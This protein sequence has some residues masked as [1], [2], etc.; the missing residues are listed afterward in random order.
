MA[1]SARF[2]FE[3]AD[4]STTLV[5]S[6]GIPKTATCFGTAAIRTAQKSQGSSSLRLPGGLANYA[7]IQA[8]GSELLMTGDYSLSIWAYRDVF[9]ADECIFETGANALDLQASISFSNCNILFGTRFGVTGG[10]QIAS[11]SNV[12]AGEWHNYGFMRKGRTT[13]AFVDGNRIGSFT[14][15]TGLY[16]IDLSTIIIG[17]RRENTR[18][19]TG[20][21][22]DLF[23]DKGEALWLYGYDPFTLAPYTFDPKIVANQSPLLTAQLYPYPV[24][25]KA[26]LPLGVVRREYYGGT[27]RIYGTVKVK[28]T[29][30]NVPVSRK[31]RLYD[32]AQGLP[33][34]ETWSHPETG[35]YEFAGYNPNIRYMVLSYDFTQ[36]YRAVVADMLIAEV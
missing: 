2:F 11:A 16:N 3:G 14:D 13:F 10:A 29:P 25:Y 9:L 33:I 36:S 23:I 34:A 17:K 19:M 26:T 4:G 28:G 21:V 31:V 18:P 6:S 27:A 24:Q 32:Q 15:S 30:T 7:Q 5:D 20:Y 12:P 8:S 1:L 22:D 35:Y